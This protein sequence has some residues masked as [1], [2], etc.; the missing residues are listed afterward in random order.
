[1]KFTSF[2]KSSALK[3]VGAVSLTLALGAGLVGCGGNGAGGAVA[4]TVNG[5]NIMEQTVTDYV[6]Q[7]RADSG[8]ESDEAWGEWMV[9]NNYTPETVREEVIEYYV[10]QDLYDQAAAEYNVAVEQADIDEAMEQTKAMFESEEAF[11][12][13]L[14][15]SG[16]TEETYI[17]TNLRP[18]LMES[19]L[20]EAVANAEN[21]GGD[22][23]L[24]AQAQS[25]SDQ[26]NGAKRTS[27]ILLTAEGDETDEA[28]QARAQALIDQI[29][30]G[31][32]SFEDAVSQNSQDSGSAAK[33]GDV[34]WNVLNNFVTEYTDAVA[35]LNKGDMTASP[36]K[37]EFGYHIIKCTDVFEVPEG[38]ITSL[39]QLPTEFVDALRNM[40]SAAAGQNF[41]TW[42]QEYRENAEVTVNPMP[43]GLPYAIDIAPYQKAAEEKAAAAEGE[44]AADP[45]AEGAQA[46]EGDQA[47]AEGDAAGA[48]QAPAEGDAAGAEGDAAGAD[49]APA[50]GDAAGAGADQ[51]PAQG[52]AAPAEGDAAGADQAPA[53]GDAAGA[54][55]APAEG[56]QAPEQQ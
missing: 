44:P 2:V 10:K 43:E 41:T 38:G 7:F 4:A 20:A 29:N 3:R 9:A 35:G 16:M 15:A 54:D 13:A 33:G 8:L 19:K 30:A 40:Q 45:T 56:G 24:L 34:G 42:Y 46:A 1:M 6:A 36:V 39:D 50:E 47:P 11:K 49:Q 12:E 23:A 26:F 14:E 22:E 5:Q 25:A 51:A 55:Q 21:G 17:E 18:R 31:T 32:I 37:S 27:H 53:E 48:D 28:L 52:D